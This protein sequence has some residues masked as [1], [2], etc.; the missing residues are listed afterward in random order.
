MKRFNIALI[1]ASII[2]VGAIMGYIIHTKI[3]QYGD[4][5]PMNQPAPL[6]SMV[7]ERPHEA[8]VDLPEYRPAPIQ[9]Y[10]RPQA[11][12]QVGLL[13]SEDEN[14]DLR[15]IYAKPVRGHRDRFHYWSTG[16]NGHNNYSVPLTMD[17]RDCTD[18]IGC[19]EIYGNE[20]VSVWDNP[21][22][23][24]KSHVYRHDLFF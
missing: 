4:V 24:Y 13:K 3:P 6:E 21:E 5:V 17:G 15:P 2:L 18:D 10:W 16:G 23:Q 1:V 20:S 14:G 9:K 19:Q 22:I 8:L 12:H 11:P 7:V